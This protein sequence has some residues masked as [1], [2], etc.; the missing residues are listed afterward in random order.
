MKLKQL[1]CLTALSIPFSA[2]ADFLSISVGGGAWNDLANGHF[3]HTNDPAVDV[4]DNLFWGNESQGYLFATF[5]HFVP[6]IPNFRLMYT[7]INHTGSGNTSFTFDGQTY[8]GNVSNDFD[9]QT[10]DLTAYY[11]VLDNIVSLDIGLTIRQLK[12]DYTI[13]DDSGNAT[14]D[15]IDET[16]PMLYAL[17]GASPYPGLIISGELS[18]IAFDGSSMSDFIAKI[19]YTTDFFIGFEGGYRKQNFEFYDVSDTNS[20]LNFDGVFVGAYLKF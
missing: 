12:V 3:Q 15:T 10:T 13:S 16:L 14:T 2:H 7:S 11:E 6:L 1:A 8:A 17:V 20:N 5:E 4:N 18:Y 19:A 9:I